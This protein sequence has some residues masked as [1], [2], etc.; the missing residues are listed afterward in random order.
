AQAFKEVTPLSGIVLTKMDGT[1]N[2]GIIFTIKDR[3]DMAVKLIGLGEKID[4]LQEFDL[5]SYI[6]GL[7]KGLMPNEE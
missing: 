7:M 4:D 5:D 1:S 3:L 6:Y 2:G